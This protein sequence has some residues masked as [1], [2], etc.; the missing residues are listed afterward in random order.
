MTSSGTYGF[1][2]SIGEIVLYCFNRC[3]VRNTALVQE[4]MESA[5]MAA[6]MVLADFSNRGVNLWAVDLQ[7]IPLV[8]G[9]STYDVPGN[10][11]VLLDGYVVQNQ[12]G[13]AI[14]RLLLPVSRSEYASYPNPQMQGQPTVYWFDRLI[15]PTVTLWPVPN[16]EQTSFNYYRLRQLQD[17]EYTDS[18][19]A[20]VPYLWLKA[21]SDALS[22]ELA[23][24]WAPERLTFLAP[25]ADKSYAIAANQ[26]VETEQVYISPMVSAYFRA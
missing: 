18:Q 6:N 11:V 14:N 21:F 16:G 26:N 19:T 3:G 23:V 9:T 13:A 7:T 15:S 20:N 17:A 4:H 2:P 12:G 24:T 5:R 10:T 25:M 8:K 1:N 22:V